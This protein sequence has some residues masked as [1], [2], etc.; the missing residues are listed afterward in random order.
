MPFRDTNNTES[1]EF[2]YILKT[3]YSMEKISNIKLNLDFMNLK[4]EILNKILKSMKLASHIWYSTMSEL[5]D[6]NI[7][8]IIL[9]IC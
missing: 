5:I 2:S 9:Y 6:I 7:N 1:K 3:H 4:D 8:R